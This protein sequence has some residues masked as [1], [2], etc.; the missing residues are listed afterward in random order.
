MTLLTAIVCARFL[1]RNGF[2]R[3]GIVQ[4]TANMVS[5]LAALGLGITATKYVADL[6]HRDPERAGRIIGLT[7]TVAAAAG[8]AAALISLMTARPM[9]AIL[10]HAPELTNSVRIA[11]VI[12]FLNAMLAYQN[13]ALLGFEAF[14]GLARV[15]L[16]AGL[17]SLPVIAFGVWR[18]D[19]NGAVTG[20]AVSLAVSWWLNERLLK[21]ECRKARI[22]IRIRRG[23]EEMTVFW[24]FG[25]PALL[26][27]VVNAPVLWL[28]SVW[29]VRAPHG[30]S[31]MALY[32]ATDR[33]RLAIL[34]IPTALFR[35]ALPMLANLH[36]HNRDAY[37]RVA[38]ANLGLNLMIVTVSLI[39]VVSLSPWIM[40]SYGSGFRSGWPVLILFCIGTI[41]EALNTILGYPLIASGRMWVRCGFDVALSAILLVL[42]A[43]LIPFYGARG[44]AYAYFT[45]YSTISIGLYFVTRSSEAVPDSV[46]DSA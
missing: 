5:A 36:Q 12:V 37:R 40:E 28:C 10:I 26:G 8:A 30:F 13:G 7:W 1:G 18:W 2:G 6:R 20:T 43:R 23:F 27:A 4:S 45:A 15:N 24:N 25:L 41:P 33:W 16:A 46:I 31:Q 3:F 11:S 22:P 44:L 21:E 32:S 42:G 9:T 39:G 14:R 35:S 38:R 19:V 17:V 29:M 34:F